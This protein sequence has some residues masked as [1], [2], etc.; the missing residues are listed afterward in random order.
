MKSRPNR[1]SH[2]CYCFSNCVTCSPCTAQSNS[3]TFPFLSY[4]SNHGHL[5]LPN[6][7]RSFP[8]PH[9]VPSSGLT[10]PSQSPLSFYSGPPSPSYHSH[11]MQHLLLS[12][13]SSPVSTQ[14]AFNL[15]LLIESGGGREAKQMASK[16]SQGMGN[17]KPTS[18][19]CY[20]CP[21]TVHGGT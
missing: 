7:R 10:L 21:I 1:N 6:H 11:N 19:V 4:S 5:S 20:F 16:C 2:L 17:M 9:T 12:N 15:S 13:Y 18:L 3:L 14:V 8:F